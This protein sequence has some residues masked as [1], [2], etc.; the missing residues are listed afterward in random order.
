MTLRA[1]LALALV[2]AVAAGALVF[3]VAARATVGRMLYSDVDRDLRGEVRQTLATV[4]NDERRGDAQGVDGLTRRR[5][6]DQRPGRFFGRG[7]LYAQV[8][9]ANGNT[10]RTSAVEA[11][12][13][14]PDPE[15]DGNESGIHIRTTRIGEER[16]RIA[17]A[18]AADGDVVQVARPLEELTGFLDTLLWVL[19]AAGLTA[20]A[21][22][23]LLGRWAARATLRP[24]GRM[25]RTA[26][27]IASS[28]RDLSARVEPAFP[29]PELAEF[30]TS[31]NEMLA[32]I[33]LADQHQRR[34]VADASHE[35]RTPL[36][37]LG[38]NVSYLGR[39]AALDGDARDALEAVQR[40]VDRLVR[41]SD[42]LT[43]L[44]RLDA[45]PLVQLEPVDV[46][47]IAA[48]SIERAQRAFP[49]H[50]YTLVGSAGTH[51]LDVELVR[52][53]LANLLDNAGRYTPDATRVTCTLD[54]PDA[55]LV[56][57]VVSDDGPGLDDEDRARV[58]ERFHR[59]ATSTGVPGT[60]LG[61]AIVDASARA[62]GGTLVLEE[63]E[64]TGLRAVVQLHA[65]SAAPNA[66]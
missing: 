65:G 45:A 59:G 54:A 8:R 18:V 34:F 55:E 33:E 7:A 4:A 36:T 27:E 10:L 2:V 26:R 1:R 16:F 42:G 5:L 23:A 49:D 43:V 52:R 3:G 66:G 13:G 44:A 61:L 46:D 15:V 37:S 14:F 35:L 40:D 38:G 20:L 12:G 21:A 24:V 47:V 19:L 51:L 6:G 31:M 25:T 58:L 57:I 11:I 39:H 56:R 32:S 50:E 17:E 28:P 29:D 53:V 63:A 9:D 62:L 60:G 64:P 48:E 30:A 41:I 22:A